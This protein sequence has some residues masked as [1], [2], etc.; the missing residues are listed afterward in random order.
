[1]DGNE[2]ESWEQIGGEI[3]RVVRGLALTGAGGASMEK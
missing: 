3:S 1:M 2:G